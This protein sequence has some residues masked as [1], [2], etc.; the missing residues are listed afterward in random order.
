MR[1]ALIRRTVLLAPML[2]TTISILACG[3]DSPS[4]PSGNTNGTMIVSIAISPPVLNLQVGQTA[5]LTV[6]ALSSTGTA[7]S[8][9]TFT[10]S[11]SNAA[12]A[13]VSSSGVVTALTAGSTTISATSEGVTASAIATI[14]ANSA[15]FAIFSKISAG[16]HH[17]CALTA[18][19][20]AYCWGDPTYGETGTG[21][22]APADAASR[23]RQHRLH[24]DLRGVDAHVRPHR[25][26]R[27]LLLGQKF[28]RRAR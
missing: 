25:Q 14:T 8:G 28:V 9:K 1:L 2:W 23:R 21:D 24:L 17:T 27:R 26:R 19:G 6:T 16:Q 22:V 18:A 11:S 4:S 13:S 7:L 20:K 12:V 15:G 3:G 5:T 10:W